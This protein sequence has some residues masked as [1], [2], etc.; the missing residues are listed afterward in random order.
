MHANKPGAYDLLDNQI[1]P[2]RG[3]GMH[4]LDL[5]GIAAQVAPGDQLALLVYGEEDQYD[6]T[7]SINIA[8]PAVVPVTI[9]GNVYLP[10]TSAVPAP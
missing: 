5:T 9:S 7:G 2:V 8:S 6:A 10:L 4:T 1:A 3:V